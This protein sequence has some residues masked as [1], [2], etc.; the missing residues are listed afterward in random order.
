MQTPWHRDATHSAS[1][2]N[3]PEG[4]RILRMDVKHNATPEAKK[5][6][7]EEAHAIIES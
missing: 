5:I 1:R 2:Y 4:C 7:G 3:V 6:K